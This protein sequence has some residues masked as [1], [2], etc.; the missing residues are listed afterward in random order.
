MRL[1]SSELKTAEQKRIIKNLNVAMEDTFTPNEQ[2][3]KQ[4]KTEMNKIS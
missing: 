4:K 1:Q 3:T 2:D